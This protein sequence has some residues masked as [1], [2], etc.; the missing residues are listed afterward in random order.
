MATAIG[1]A[2]LWADRAAAA[3]DAPKGP[4]KEAAAGPAESSPPKNSVS[5]NATNISK[6]CCCGWQN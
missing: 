4:A 5:P 1:S 3:A 6:T 2:W